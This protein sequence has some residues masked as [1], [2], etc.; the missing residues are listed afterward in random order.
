MISS[1]ICVRIE[2]L[3]FACCQGQ[4]AGLFVFPFSDL[5]LCSSCPENQFIL[6]NGKACVRFAFVF[7]SF[8]CS[9][10]FKK[11]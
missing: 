2:L 1:V 10:R 8:V 4:L 11:N 7:N 3:L 9:L 5:S 6:N